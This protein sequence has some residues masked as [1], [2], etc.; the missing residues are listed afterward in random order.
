MPGSNSGF[1]QEFLGNTRAA[2]SGTQLRADQTQQRLGARAPKP[3]VK[4][5]GIFAEYKPSGI[6]VQY[7]DNK[8][9][10]MP[11]LETV[12]EQIAAEAGIDMSNSDTNAAFLDALVTDVYVNAYSDKQAFDGEIVVRDGVFS[13][14][15]RCIKAVLNQHVGTMYRRYARA[16]APLVVEVMHDNSDYWEIL[17]KRATELNLSTRAE[18]VLSFDGADALA[19]VSRDTARRNAEAKA[20]ALSVRS[21]HRAYSMANSAATT[22]YHTAD[23]V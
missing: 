12:L 7:A 1:E 11:G 10:V 9:G 2:T 5:I 15:R 6:K 3:R 22:G 20:L 17:D 14:P 23:S 4:A 16:M 13:M 21:T 8:V 19:E 18:A